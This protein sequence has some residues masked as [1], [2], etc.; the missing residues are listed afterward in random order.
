[1]WSG[2]VIK[3]RED[4]HKMWAFSVQSVLRQFKTSPFSIVWWHKSHLG[5]HVE[6]HNKFCSFKGDETFFEITRPSSIG[7]WGG[8]CKLTS[9]STRYFGTSHWIVKASRFHGPTRNIWDKTLILN[10]NPLSLDFFLSTNFLSLRDFSGC[11]QA[12]SN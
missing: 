8:G 1:M 7:I 5:M 6:E 4:K 10:W 11:C 9:N 3:K 2:S 12:H